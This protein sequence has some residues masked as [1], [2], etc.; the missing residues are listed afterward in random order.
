VHQTPHRMIGFVRLASPNETTV[1]GPMA[2][3]M[4]SSDDMVLAHLVDQD[5]QEDLS[6]NDCGVPGERD[7]I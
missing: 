7:E 1:F 4:K 6:E 5:G 2:N 3:M